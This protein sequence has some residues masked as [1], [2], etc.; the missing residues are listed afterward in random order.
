M[1]LLHH[2][3][4]LREEDGVYICSRCGMINPTSEQPCI[5]APNSDPSIEFVVQ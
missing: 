3:P 1:E 2:Q 4:V 5:P